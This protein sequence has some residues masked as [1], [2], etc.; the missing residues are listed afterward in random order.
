VLKEKDL[1][2]ARIISISMGSSQYK[3]GLTTRQPGLGV[4]TWFEKVKGKPAAKKPEAKKEEKKKK[5]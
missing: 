3:V 1:V 2:K 4:L 5:K